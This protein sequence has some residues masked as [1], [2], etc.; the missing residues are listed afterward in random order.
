MVNNGRCAEV[1]VQ[2]G[3]NPGPPTMAMA[4][5][6]SCGGGACARWASADGA[7]G[8]G[9]LGGGLQQGGWLT[10]TVTVTGDGAGDG[11]RDGTHTGWWTDGRGGCDAQR[12]VN[13]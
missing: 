4:A 8:G 12:A 6:P 7:V 5:R 2:P 3:P 13:R 9:G 1:H 11:R 10:V